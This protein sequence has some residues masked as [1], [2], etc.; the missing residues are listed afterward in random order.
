MPTKTTPESTRFRASTWGNRLVAALLVLLL[1]G[2]VLTLVVVG[3][4]VL[5]ITPAA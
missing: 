3:L 1:L 2:L 5:G 4:S